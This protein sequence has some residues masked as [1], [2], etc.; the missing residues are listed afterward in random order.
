MRCGAVYFRNFQ[1]VIED[2]PEVRIP[3]V[4]KDGTAYS[5]AR[6]A[7]LET[8]SAEPGKTFS[9]SEFHTAY[10]MKCKVSDIVPGNV[11]RTVRKALM[12]LR[13]DGLIKSLG[14]GKW[15]KA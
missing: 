11:T 9:A 4:T 13:K 3:V 14:T 7:I 6:E 2:G 5:C 10:R 12:M 8:V 15:M 1:S